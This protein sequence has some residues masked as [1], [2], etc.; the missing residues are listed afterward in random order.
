LKGHALRRK[1]RGGLSVGVAT[2][3]NRFTRLASRAGLKGLRFH[4]LRHSFESRLAEEGA[5]PYAIDRAMGHAS[6]ATTKIYIHT[7]V[8]NLR[9]L[10]S[11]VGAGHRVCTAR[12]GRAG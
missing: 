9:A 1:V 6:I 5:N 2:N 4:D 12:A 8:R 11:R 10:V 7:Q 3:S